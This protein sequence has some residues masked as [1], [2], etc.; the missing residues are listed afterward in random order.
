MD[1][2][3]ADGRL[4][5]AA[6]SLFYEHGVQAVGMDR[7]RAASGVSLKRLYQRFPSKEVLVEAYLRRRDGRWRG[8]L[9]AYV[10]AR[11]SVAER[12]LAVFDWLEEWFGEPDF[13]GCAFINAYGELGSGSAGVAGAVRD[14]KAE[15]LRYLTGLVR[16]AGV[17]DP[18][19][20]AEQLAV[21]VDGAITTAAVT[22]AADSARRAREAAAVLLE[23]AGAAGAAGAA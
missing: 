10:A 5:D 21:L 11:P 18:G 14:H 22:G 7:I 16:A 1:I 15:V 17:A 19:P 6:E 12:P 4:L 20:V 8:A 2:A 13:R 3:E 9:A 23:A